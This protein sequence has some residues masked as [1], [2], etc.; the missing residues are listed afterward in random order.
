MKGCRYPYSHVSSDHV[1]SLGVCKVRGHGQYKHSHPDEIDF[2][3]PTE[4]PPELYCTVLRCTRKKYHM[5]IAHHCLC[6]ER[7]PDDQCPSKLA[8]DSD[9]S[10]DFISYGYVPTDVLS[11][12]ITPI[13]VV[14]QKGSLKLGNAQGKVYTFLDAGMG[15]CWS[16]RQDDL[17]ERCEVRFIHCDECQDPNSL[18]AT[19]FFLKGYQR[20]EL[21]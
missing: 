4:L 5:T 2:S 1:C 14:A 16:V 12:A 3:G 17:D 7:H 6:G 9:P 11:P 10:L 18:I 13:H 20:V 8:R 19:E 15:C 21:K